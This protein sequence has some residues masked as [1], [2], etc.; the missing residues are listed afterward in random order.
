VLAWIEVFA[1]LFYARIKIRELVL[2]M[3]QNNKMMD[4]L[5]KVLCFSALILC[6]LGC[7]NSSPNSRVSVA[8]N[9]YESIGGQDKLESYRACVLLGELD[10]SKEIIQKIQEHIESTDNNSTCHYYL[11]AKRSGIP[12]DITQFIDKFPQGEYQKPIWQIHSEV[13]Y[14]ISFSSPYYTFLINEARNN[15]SA[16]NK[17]ISGLPYADASYGEALTDALAD[18]YSTSPERVIKSL[19]KNNTSDK[20]IKFIVDKSKYIT[21]GK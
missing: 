18:F 4:S 20:E 21:R 11:L 7:V 2:K 14:P 19:K 15:N 13:G 16:L 17:L 6:L 9:L 1:Y 3:A 8:T 10:L 12:K 5:M